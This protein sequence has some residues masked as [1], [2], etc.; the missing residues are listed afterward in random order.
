HIHGANGY[1]IS[2]FSSPVTNRRTDRWGNDAAGRDRLALEIVRRVRAA[3]PP[4]HGLSMKLGFVDAVT[5]GARP[6]QARPPGGPSRGGRPRRHRGVEQRYARLCRLRHALRRRRPL[7]RS[8]RPL[9]PS[10]DAWRARPRGVLPPLGAR[11][12]REGRHHNRSRGR[13]PPHGDHGGD[14]KEPR[15]RLPRAGAPVRARARPRPPARRRPAWPRRL[16]VVQPVSHA[17]RLSLPPLLA[18]P[19]SS[20]V[21]PRPLPPPRRLPP[22]PRHPPLGTIRRLT[23][24]R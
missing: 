7:T 5:G 6:H 17:R 18:H 19:P 1:L 16:H 13:P 10:R 20:V 14:P 21:A 24:G 3:V 4:T 2:E 22:R 9:A 8:R 12:A 23:R 11:L 15:R